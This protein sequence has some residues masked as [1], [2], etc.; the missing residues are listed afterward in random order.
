MGIVHHVAWRLE[1]DEE[2]MALRH[3][4]VDELGF[5]VTEL[6]DR[7]YF[8]SIYFRIPGGVLFEVA[9]VRPGF[10]IDEKESALGQH[11]QLPAWE[12]ENRSKIEENLARVKW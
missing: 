3:R 6:K 11:L 1:S 2:L 12:E 4:L 9:T 5:K 10:T 7:K 8:R